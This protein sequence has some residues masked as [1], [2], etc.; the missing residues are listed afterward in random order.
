MTPNIK[1]S[2]K[3]LTKYFPLSHLPKKTKMLLKKTDLR[4]QY[5]DTSKN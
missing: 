2:R 5:V 1:E 3:P 4:D